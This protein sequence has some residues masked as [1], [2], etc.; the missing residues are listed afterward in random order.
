MGEERKR[1][2]VG[3]EFTREIAGALKATINAH[4]P[5]TE[6]SVSSAAKRVKHALREE[7][8]RERDRIALSRPRAVNDAERVEVALEAAVR[9]ALRALRR[10][11]DDP[12][13]RI[14]RASCAC[15]YTLAS[16]GISIFLSA[17]TNSVE[18]ND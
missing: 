4:G 7:M 9:A 5:I 11:G 17:S 8:K 18:P 12:E 14:S 10:E 16:S 2:R 15:S 13:E 3:E 6:G 1:T